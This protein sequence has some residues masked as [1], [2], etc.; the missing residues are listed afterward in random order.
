MVQ[1]LKQ[2]GNTELNPE[3][4]LY[5]CSKWDQV[6]ESEAEEVFDEVL[7]RL[8][9]EGIEVKEG[10]LLKLSVRKV[11]FKLNFNEFCILKALILKIEYNTKYSLIN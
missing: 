3:C 1:E 7:S 5:V 6:D 9:S 10:Q 8:R 2:D 4:T 11:E